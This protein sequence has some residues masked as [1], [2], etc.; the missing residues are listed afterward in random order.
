MIGASIDRY[1]HPQLD[2]RTSRALVEVADQA[3][4]QRAIDKARAELA[5]E[6]I[7]D[8]QVVTQHGLMAATEIAVVET[9]CADR[10]PQATGRLAHIANIGTA[11]IGSVLADLGRSL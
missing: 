11:A 4:T 5:R 7:S 6:R 8:L 10:A 3:L 2:R 1:R 9:W